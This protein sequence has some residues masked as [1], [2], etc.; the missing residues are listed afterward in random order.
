MSSIKKRGKFYHYKTY[1]NGKEYRRSLH[2]CDRSEARHLQDVLDLQFSKNK[3]PFALQKI[4]IQQ[5]L[6]MFEA[7]RKNYRSYRHNADSLRRINGFITWA[8]IQFINDIAGLKLTEYINKKI[9]D[10]K[11]VYEANNI[12]KDMKTF[13]NW[14]VRNK[15]LFDSPLSAVSKLPIQE[16]TR[17]AYEGNELINIIKAAKNERLYPCVMTA[18]YTGMRKGELFRLTWADVSFDTNTITLTNT[19]SK[20]VK[21]V[22]IAKDLK[23]ILWPL[24]GR[25]DQRCFDITN[26]PRVLG[27]IF[28]KAGI[29]HDR[30]WH[31]FRHTN[32]THLL[33]NGVDIKTVAGILG[34]HSTNVTQVYVHTTPETMT[35][36]VNK[37]N[38]RHKI[39]HT[40]NKISSAKR[41]K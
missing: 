17:R 31:F 13:I 30:G 9:A 25:A 16:T 29:E 20:R 18:L 40:K 10:G 21:L 19:K 41:K 26:H 14:G 37:L 27:R 33:R 5:I 4:P 24:R 11:S 32:A 39:G 38:F 1:I 12:I 22:P 15:F 34:H 28:R 2:T 35:R 23:K 3:N 8:S 36:A 6:S 7:D